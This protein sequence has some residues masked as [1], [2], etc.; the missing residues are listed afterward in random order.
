MNK[1][2]DVNDAVLVQDTLLGNKYAFEELVVRYQKSVIGAAFKITKNRFSA[3]D[4]ASD[5]FLSAW[6][7]LDCLREYEKF[8]PWVARIARNCAVSLVTR[9]SCAAADISLNLLENVDFEG[10]S[11]DDIIELICKGEPSEELNMR[12]A[13]LS[14]KIRTV[15]NLHYFEGL[16][17]EQIANRLS[18]PAGTV[19]WRLSEGR[20]QLRKGYGIMEKTYDENENLVARVM[21]MVEQ[22]K[23]WGLKNSKEGFES[24]YNATLAAV[25]ELDDSKEKSHA[26]ADVLLRGIWW[27]PG[28]KNEEIVKKIKEEAEKGRNE[29]VLMDVMSSNHSS[30]SGEALIKQMTET[31]IPYCIENGFVKLEAYVRFWLAHQYFLDNPEKARE[32]FEKV[33]ELLKPSDIYY[34]NAKSAV[35]CL[36]LTASQA[37]KSSAYFVNCT[38]ESYK[39]IDG[40]LYFW[41][42]PGFE[43][44]IKR[45]K[46]DRCYSG[47]LF[48][49]FSL[50]DSIIFD[51]EMKTGD[52]KNPPTAAQL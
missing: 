40:K 30:L 6:T 24:V 14:E 19:K 3:E 41:S 11:E 39:I 27:I 35:R 16:T 52:T 49:W 26:L 44:H 20:K 42:Q 46:Y 51:P 5:A 12:L 21:R 1:Y 17:V 33:T 47:S 28:K 4:A 8:G 13:E 7:H 9:Y 43:I 2:T 36:D 23:L 50:C 48:Y 38:A 29:D 45:A 10:S 34:A 32:Q 22:M 25:E 15:I 37:E 31:D 18:L